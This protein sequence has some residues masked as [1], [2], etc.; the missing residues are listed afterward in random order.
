MRKFLKKFG[1][2]FAKLSTKFEETTENAEKP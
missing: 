2:N 1:R